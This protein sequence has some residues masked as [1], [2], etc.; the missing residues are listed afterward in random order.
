MPALHRVLVVATSVAMLSAVVAGAANA[1]PKNQWPFTRST[2]S[3]A[4]TQSRTVR[5]VDPA[6]MPEPK[7]ELPFTRR[8]DTGGAA[9]G[10]VATPTAGGGSS[11]IDW[12]LAG[13]AS[14][15]AISLVG[16]AFVLVREARVTTRSRPA[17]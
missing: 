8:V 7:N 4:L 15:V 17:A 14:L 11:G 16:G 3:R 13:W 12:P 2:D 10:D 6:P 1:E 9:S 5:I